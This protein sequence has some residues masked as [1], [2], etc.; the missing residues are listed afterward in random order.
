MTGTVSPPTRTVEI[1]VAEL[2]YAV[3]FARLNERLW[4]RVDTLLNFAQVMAGALALAGAFGDAKTLAGAGV[5][6][7][8]VSGLQI[9]L[10]PSR[11]GADFRMARAAWQRLARD[12]WSLSLSELDARMED[13]RSESPQGFDALGPAAFNAVQMRHGNP[14]RLPLRWHQRLVAA[15]A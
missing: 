8:L 10:Q 15:L 7:A 13:L 4:Q 1:A 14:A 2:R 3:E 5:A 11:R 12:P 6:M 9:G